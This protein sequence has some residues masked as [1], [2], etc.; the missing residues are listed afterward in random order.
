M[1]KEERQQKLKEMKDLFHSMLYEYPDWCHTQFL[2]SSNKL[3]K[4]IE[5]FI[6]ED[7]D[8]LPQQLYQIGQVLI[9]TIFECKDITI[10]I[11][12]EKD[13]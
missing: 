5:S 9:E 1:N 11:E 10:N 7:K 3:G 6:E 2:A 8:Y 13:E 4:V 12:G